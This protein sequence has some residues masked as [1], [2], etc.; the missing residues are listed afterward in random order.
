ME[1][2]KFKL[3]KLRTEKEEAIEKCEDAERGKKEAI[4]ELD[5]VRVSCC[6]S[7]AQFATAAV[8][9]ARSR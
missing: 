7:I 4:D 5:K 8:G 3:S 6:A 9:S 1:A 2:I